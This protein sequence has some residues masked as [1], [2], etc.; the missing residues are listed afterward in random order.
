MSNIDTLWK[1][2]PATR[3]VVQNDG[4][5]VCIVPPRQSDELGHLIA[6]APSLMAIAHDLHDSLS[7][8]LVAWDGEEDSVKEEH[9]DLIAELDA[10]D[11]RADAVLNAA[12]A[13]AISAHTL[14][15]LARTLLQR[16]HELDGMQ[17]YIVIHSHRHGETFYTTWSKEA[18][19]EQH[20]IDL[21]VEE[22]E[23]ERGE[24][25]SYQALAI[26]DMTG[27]PAVKDHSEDENDDQDEQSDRPSG[28]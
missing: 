22:F 28:M 16:A 23:P 3:T 10:A 24:W 14:R 21:L 8:S 20:M 7:E 6:A 17:P 11:R 12:G 4:G 2:D 27:A 18:P 13:G 5:I 1:F 26:A 15:E 25:I 19:S 9:A